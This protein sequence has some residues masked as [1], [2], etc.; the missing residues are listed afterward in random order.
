MNSLWWKESTLQHGETS[1]NKNESVHANWTRIIC[2]NTEL[3]KNEKPQLFGHNVNLPIQKAN[4]PMWILK[5]VKMCFRQRG[6][7][8]IAS[9]E[10]IYK[11]YKIFFVTVLYVWQWKQHLFAREIEWEVTWSQADD[12]SITVL[13]DKGH[14]LSKE[15]SWQAYRFWRHHLLSRHLSTHKQRV[16]SERAQ[17]H[18]HAH[19]STCLKLT[20]FTLHTIS[21]VLSEVMIRE[22]SFHSLFWFWYLIEK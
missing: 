6:R 22:G 1:I 9:A 20:L 7:A 8:G 14:L 16:M 3:L 18:M 17:T 19:Q 13:T 2:S 5:R 12:M 4:S 15:T 21:D 11:S 10:I